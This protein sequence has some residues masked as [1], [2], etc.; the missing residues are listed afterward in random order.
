M[1]NWSTTPPQGRKFALI[2]TGWSYQIAQWE[3]KHRS[4]SYYSHAYLCE[5]G[6][7]TLWHPLPTVPGVDLSNKIYE[8]EK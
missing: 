5:A 8:F 6:P 7:D 4:W 1:D 3:P 2:W